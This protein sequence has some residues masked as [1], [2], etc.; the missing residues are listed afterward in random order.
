MKT[1]LLLLVI[2]CL[3]TAAIYAQHDYSQDVIVL[4]KEG[5]KSDTAI[6]KGDI[7]IFESNKLKSF[8]Q[9]KT[10][11]E[12]AIKRA[13]PYFEENDTIVRLPDGK[14]LNQSNMSK[15]YRIKVPKNISKQNL[16]DSLN[17][18]PEVVYAES[19]VNIVPLA[20]PT[21]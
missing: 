8:F 10:I 20:T 14:I 17:N 5:M 13:M 7:S 6:T 1:K 2:L 12:T 18:L 16:I 3:A 21:I 11:S 15:L 9:R 4:F 19:D